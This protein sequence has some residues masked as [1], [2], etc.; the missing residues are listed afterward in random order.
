LLV[1]AV[2][3]AFAGYGLS[4]LFSRLLERFQRVPEAPPEEK[5]QEKK[6]R[7]EREEQEKREEEKRRREALGANVAAALIIAG[8]GFVLVEVVLYLCWAWNITMPWL[9]RRLPAGSLMGL[10]LGIYL[11]L[12]IRSMPPVHGGVLSRLGKRIAEIKEGPYLILIGLDRVQKQSLEL[13][14]VRVPGPDGEVRSV[15]A[16][17]RDGKYVVPTLRVLWRVVDVWK[18]VEVQIE[19][20]DALGAAVLALVRR[21]AAGADPEK[22]KTMMDVL[23]AI[24]ALGKYVERQLKEYTSTWGIT[25]TVLL[26]DIDPIEAIKTAMVGAAAAKHNKEATITNADAEREARILAARAVQVEIQ[27][28]LLA[29]G[30]LE[31]QDGELRVVKEKE[32]E[33]FEWFLA[34]AARDALIKGEAVRW[35]ITPANVVTLLESLL[36]KAKA[37]TQ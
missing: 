23:L 25:V 32:K 28:Q 27:R 11:I 14:E 13:R 19:I 4:V 33:V 21:F 37:G 1:L 8:T 26:E 24:E 9:P 16:I 29:L 3:V 31:E 15:D 10:F 5:E 18:F 17:T 6:E 12:G 22:E 35:V 7:Q 20:A 36:N 2:A 30:L 34:S